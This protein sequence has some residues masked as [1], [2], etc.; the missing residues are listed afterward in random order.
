MTDYEQ[1]LKKS[2]LNAWPSTQQ[3][4]C[5]FHINKNVAWNIK[6]KWKPTAD[7]DG[8]ES[9]QLPESAQKAQNEQALG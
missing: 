6:R 9:N 7:D 4:L 5:I 2:L 8:V 1:G 3:Q